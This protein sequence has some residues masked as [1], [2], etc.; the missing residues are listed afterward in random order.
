MLKVFYWELLGG[1]VIQNKMLQNVD[2]RGRN[3]V[4]SLV[5]KLPNRESL[6]EKG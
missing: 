4:G 5:Q 2:Y 3:F 1:K 6:N